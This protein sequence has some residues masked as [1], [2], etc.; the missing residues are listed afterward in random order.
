MHAPQIMRIIFNRSFFQKIF[1]WFLLAAIAYFFRDFFIIF[2][3]TFLFAY[4]FSNLWEFI[5]GKLLTLFKHIK[6]KES[7]ARFEKLANLNFLV[8]L[9]YLAFI[10]VIIFIISSL[11]PKIANDLSELAKQIPFLQNQMDLALTKLKEIKNINQDIQS[12]VSQ[13]F[14]TQNLTIVMNLLEKLKSLWAFLVQF[15]ISLILSYI[16]VV[17]KAKVKVYLEN[18]KKGNFAFIYYEYEIVFQKIVNSFGMIFKAQSMV[19]LFNSFFTAVWLCII[20][21]VN[22]V[23]TSNHGVVTGTPFPYFPYLITLALVVFILGFVPV[24]WVFLSSIPILIIGYTYFPGASV[25]VVIEIVIMITIIHAIEAYYLNPR[26]VSSYS[27]FPMSL[28]LLMLLLWENLF[29]MV[30]LLI[31]VPIFYLIIDI[32]KETDK[33]IT[34]VRGITKAVST[35]ESLTREA[36]EDNIRL[37]RSGKRAEK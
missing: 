36:I 30:W 23:L 18:I 14:S 1:A 25:N 26:I 29:G 22:N 34:R 27:S 31:W 17:D 9:V 13:V 2:L 33:Y 7:R 11:V 28:T 10:G 12:T 4:L 21:F 19:A 24:V 6:N 5:R 3:M 15:I 20:G 37:S 35:A 8:L 32:M 16:L